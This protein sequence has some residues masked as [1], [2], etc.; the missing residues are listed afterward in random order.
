VYKTDVGLTT[1]NISKRMTSH[2]YN[3]FSFTDDDR[4]YSSLD[5]VAS[6]YNGTFNISEFP[7]MPIDVVRNNINR[8]CQETNWI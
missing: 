5:L 2:R 8:L 6:Y 4:T 1:Q 3:I 7:S